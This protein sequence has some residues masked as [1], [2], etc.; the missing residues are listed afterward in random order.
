[1]K[2]KILLNIRKIL[3]TLPNMHVIV[4]KHC[5]LKSVLFLNHILINYLMILK[6]K[7]RRPHIYM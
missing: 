2:T 7:K 6:L 1:M 3:K 5:V 4:V